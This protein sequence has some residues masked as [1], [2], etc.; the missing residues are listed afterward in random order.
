MYPAGLHKIPTGTDASSQFFE[1]SFVQKQ[2]KTLNRM[3]KKIGKK[4]VKDVEHVCP[5]QDLDFLI[6]CCRPRHNFAKNNTYLLIIDLTHTLSYS[7][8]Y[9]GETT[10]SI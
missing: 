9:L 3:R 5:E 6:D 4:T 7:I 1:N 10:E 8:G 2:P